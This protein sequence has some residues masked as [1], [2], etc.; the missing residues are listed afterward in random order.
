MQFRLAE[1]SDAQALIRLNA[2]FNEVDD[3]S[4]EDVCKS[5]S[6]A[7][8][9]VVVA[10]ADGAVVGFCCAQV[11][12]SFCYKAPVAEVTEMYVDAAF[13]RRGC[14]QGMLAC[15]EDFLRDAF[16]VD[17]MHLLTGTANLAAQSAYKKAGF[18]VKNEVYMMKEV[19]RKR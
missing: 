12:H 13:R 4:P 3:L 1:P 5:L 9:V 11:H 2:A 10:D 16:R 7:P 19:P 14:A 8:E 18:A 17:E 15:L 6:D